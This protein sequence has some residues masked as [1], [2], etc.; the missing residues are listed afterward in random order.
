MA[1]CSSGRRRVSVSPTPPLPV[2]V[3]PPSKQEAA[4]A[5]LPLYS[6]A[7]LKAYGNNELSMRDFRPVFQID[8]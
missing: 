8:Q 2:A 1:E 7:G 6:G 4:V 5:I 3:A